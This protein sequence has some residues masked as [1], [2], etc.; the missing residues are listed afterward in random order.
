M[1]KTIE[2]EGK[3]FEYDEEMA[4]DYEVIKGVVCATS[5]P[6][7]FFKSIELVFVGKDAEYARELGND[8]GKLGE[9]LTLVIETSAGKNS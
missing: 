1:I 2:F 6:A 3:T 7:G 4:T 9:L 5:N 8:L